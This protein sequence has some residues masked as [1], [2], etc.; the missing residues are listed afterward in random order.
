VTLLVA[1]PTRNN[2]ELAERLRA[3]LPGT[4]IRVWPDLGDPADIEFALV[5]TPPRGLFGQLPGLRAV[6]SLGAGVDGLIDDP[7]LPAG[8]PLGRLAG[9]RLAANMAAWLLAM[10]IG[11]WKRLAEFRDL[12]R[13]HEWRQWAP[14]HPPLIGLLG[15]GEMGARS[16]RAFLDLDIPVLGLSRS[17]RGPEG[18]EVVTGRDGLDD[19]ASKADYL[20]NLLPLTPSTRNILD[21]R[22]MAKMKTNATLINVGRGA[23]LVEADLL[24]ALDAGRP[25][26]AILDVFRTEPLPE[27]HP[28]WDHP[29]I[30][31]TPHCASITLTAE[32]AELAAESYRRVMAG[33]PPLGAVERTRG[34]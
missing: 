15:L 5:W 4:E 25:A 23:H 30:T 28:F 12:Q 24:A 9:K 6:S 1:T 13:R 20:I 32:A 27:N 21:A 18:V 19:I 17:G 11:R 31:I 26:H 2:N 14:E 29:Q 16:A 3:H 7:E 22:L 8:V 33:Q 34:Y 10:V